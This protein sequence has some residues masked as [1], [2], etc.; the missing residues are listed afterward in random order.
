MAKGFKEKIGMSV[1]Q[2]V[3]CSINSLPGLQKRI[4]PGTKIDAHDHSKIVSSQKTAGTKTTFI[5]V[6][7]LLSGLCL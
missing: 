1:S 6:R 4:N 7:P 2:N 3:N 5:S